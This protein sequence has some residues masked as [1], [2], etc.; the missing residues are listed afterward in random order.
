MNNTKQTSKLA[1][2]TIN[3]Y[4]IMGVIALVDKGRAT[5]VIYPDLGKAFNA[6]PHDILVSKLETHGFD[7]WTTRWIRNWLDGRT[8]RA[9]VNGLIKMDS[10]TECTLSKFA[11]DTKLWGTADMLEGRDAIQRD[12]DRLER[13]AHANLM[14]FNKDK[15][16]VLHMGWGNP[17]HKYS[18]GGEWI[19][20]SPME[21]GLG[22]LA[23]EKLT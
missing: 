12:L 16:K 20:S 8:Q 6:V 7:G 11:N 14:K 22:V 4:M 1:K 21:K 10:G 5:D 3:L 13:W 2:L 17:K 18:L 19:E 15:C 23:D 9:A